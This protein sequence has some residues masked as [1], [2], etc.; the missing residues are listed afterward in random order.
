ME[1]PMA[2]VILDNRESILIVTTSMGAIP[3]I[4]VSWD[5]QS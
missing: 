2:V 4:H 3:T 1:R 5:T